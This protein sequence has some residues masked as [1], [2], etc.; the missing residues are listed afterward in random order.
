MGLVRRAA[1][2]PPSIAWGFRALTSMHALAGPKYLLR[3][4]VVVCPS[5]A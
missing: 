1:Y 4:A 5:N 3:A 2:D